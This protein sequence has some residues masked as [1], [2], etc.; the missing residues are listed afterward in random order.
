[1]DSE[2]QMKESERS[3]FGLNGVSGLLIAVVLLVIVTGAL[4][5]LGT[6]TQYENA[7]KYYKIN[8]DLH[9]IKKFSKDNPK[10]RMIVK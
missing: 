1:M 6:T 5:Y 3:V 8:D 7:T 2:T 10:H 4:T 9:A